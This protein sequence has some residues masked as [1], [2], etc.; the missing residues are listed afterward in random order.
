MSRLR[1]G[2]GMALS[3]ARGHEVATLI[4]VANFEWDLGGGEVLRLAEVRFAEP[5]A[6]LVAVNAAWL[7]RWGDWSQQQCNAR[8]AR[9]MFTRMLRGFADG[10][11]LPL[12]IIDRGRLAGHVGLTIDTDQR[13]ASVGYWI[14]EQFTGTGL[15]TRAV[16]AITS[17]ALADL[18]LLRVQA[19]VAVGNTASC[20]VLQRAGFHLEG[21][22]RSGQVL[23]GH[24]HDLQMWSRLA[25][26]AARRDR[27]PL[28]VATHHNQD[29]RSCRHPVQP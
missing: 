3:P 21:A 4:A 28:N 18:G 17:H 7:D 27:S 25:D 19:K 13:S 16:N 12:L 29:L 8:L 1:F 11:R 23:A 2:C 6:E 26:D 15:A 14:G 5:Y 24:P 22:Q 9:E 10:T 20:A